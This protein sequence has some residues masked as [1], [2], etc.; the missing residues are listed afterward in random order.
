MTNGI[1]YYNQKYH[2]GKTHEFN[3]L[4]S[5]VV[6]NARYYYKHGHMWN[7]VYHVLTYI[8]ILFV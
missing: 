8:V 3:L 6:V 1:N 4:H 5:H 7:N 2:N